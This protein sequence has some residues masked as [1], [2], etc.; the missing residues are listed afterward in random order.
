MKPLALPSAQ[1]SSAKSSLPTD[2]VWT[3]GG[4]YLINAFTGQ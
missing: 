3:R 1:L 2:E 4:E